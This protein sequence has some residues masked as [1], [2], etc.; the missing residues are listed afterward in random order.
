MLQA[1]ECEQ[2]KNDGFFIVDDVVG[3]NCDFAAGYKGL[4]AGHEEVVFGTA[5]GGEKGLYLVAFHCPGNLFGD[6][7]G[8][9]S[10]KVGYAELAGGDERQEVGDKPFLAQRFRE[11]KPIVVERVEVVE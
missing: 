8:D 10:Q 5:T 6:M 2:G 11:W 1:Q 3:R 9:G 7:F 4:N